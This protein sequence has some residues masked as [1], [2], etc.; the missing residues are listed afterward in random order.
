MST[1]NINKSFALI[2]VC[3]TKKLFL[4]CFLNERIASTFKLKRNLFKDSIYDETNLMDI[5]LYNIQV[6]PFIRL[7]SIISSNTRTFVKDFYVLQ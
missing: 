2:L 6:H 5:F 1:L 4:H 3:H 7:F